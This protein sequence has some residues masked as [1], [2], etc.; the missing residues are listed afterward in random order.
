MFGE[1]LSQAFLCVRGPLQGI[2]RHLEVGSAVGTDA[3]GGDGADP[4]D[5]PQIPLPC[6]EHIFPQDLRDSLGP[7]DFGRLAE[8]GPFKPWDPLRSGT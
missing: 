3:Y 2:Q 5:Y 8:T 1:L 4:L 6:H 7:W